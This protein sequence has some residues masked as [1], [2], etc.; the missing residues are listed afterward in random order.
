MFIILKIVCLG[1]ILI[2]IS[3]WVCPFLNVCSYQYINN[4]YQ[5]STLELQVFNLQY[6]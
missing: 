4:Y 1:W 6:K 5:F 2:S 3:L